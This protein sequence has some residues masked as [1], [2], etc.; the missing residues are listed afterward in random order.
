MP[1]Y[2]SERT[3]GKALASIRNQ[4]YN[5]EEI[6][7]LVIDG[8][9]TDR[10]LDIAAKYDAKIIYNKDKV[11]EAAKIL[12]YQQARGRWIIKQDSDEVYVDKHQLTRKRKF[13]KKNPNVYLLLTDKLLAGK[14][15][16][17]ACA[18]LNY[19]GDAFSYIVYKLRGSI[20]RQNKR[21]LAKKDS[22]GNVYHYCKGDEYPIGDGGCT[23]FNIDKFRELFKDKYDS[24]EYVKLSTHKLIEETEYAGCI[25]NDNIYHYSKADI[26]SYLRKV[27]FKIHFN[28]SGDGGVGYALKAQTDKKYS[29]RKWI[30]VLYA[31]SIVLPVIDSVKLAVKQHDAS[32]LLHWFYTYHVLAVAA[33]EVI[34][35]ISK[36]GKGNY[37]YG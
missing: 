1:T 8:G 32:F 3:I 27:R 34:G 17:I 35:K 26:K 25:P 14:K 15:C 19:C 16:G 2:N 12:G 6:E 37:S 10:T 29:R 13:I 9:S 28:L 4:D 30:F 22:Y 18:Y 21:Y 24:D 23:A 31:V 11:P 20:V 7:I 5:Q 33:I 36:K